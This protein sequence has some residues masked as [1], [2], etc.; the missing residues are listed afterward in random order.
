MLRFPCR[1]VKAEKADDLPA[2]FP[3][4]SDLVEQLNITDMPAACM[5]GAIIYD[6]DRNIEQSTS[7]DPHFVRDVSRLMRAHN[8]STFLYVEDW[9]AMVTKEENGT[10]D[11]EVVA[12]GFD[13]EVRDERNSDFM[14]KVLKGKEVISKVRPVSHLLLTV[15]VLTSL[16]YRSS[17]PW[18]RRSFPLSS[19]SSRRSSP[20]FPLRSPALSPTSSRSSP[21]VSTSRLLS[22]SSAPSSTSSPRTSSLS[23]TARTSTF[24]F[25][26]SLPSS[27]LTR[28]FP[29]LQCRYVRCLRLLGRHGQRHAQA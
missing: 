2:L 3:F 28:F 13:P 25:S 23:V 1:G 10:K 5:H 27:V 15:L 22:L 9:N 7:L 20:T 12:R 19:T 29:S 16:S 11:W 24:F 14:K 21:R 6:K 26:S 18:T 4:P 8:K 17:S